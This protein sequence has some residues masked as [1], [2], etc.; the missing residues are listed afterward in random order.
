MI[1]SAYEIG[2]QDKFGFEY[3]S[4]GVEDITDKLRQFLLPTVLAGVLSFV[5]AIV[6]SFIVSLLEKLTKKTSTLTF[7]EILL[8]LCPPAFILSCWIIYSFGY[9]YDLNP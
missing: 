3:L 2:F 9:N 5:G 4:I 8:L 7:Y 6:I 1:T